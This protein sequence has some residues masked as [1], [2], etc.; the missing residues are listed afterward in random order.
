MTN[1]DYLNLTE[2]ELQ[3]NVFENG[4]VD[5]IS[6]VPSNNGTPLFLQDKNLVTQNTNYNNCRRSA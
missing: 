6:Q 1:L 3:K 2:Q 5:I 4:R